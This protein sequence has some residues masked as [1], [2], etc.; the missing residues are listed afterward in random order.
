[1]GAVHFLEMAR[2]VHT[3]IACRNVLMFQ[4]EDDPAQTIVK[5]TDFGL[6]SCLPDD[7]DHFLSR[8][9]Q[10][11]RWCAPETVASMKWSHATDV[12]SLGTSP[13]EL[14]SDGMVPWTRGGKRADVVKKLQKL[15]QA[16][17]W[18]CMDMDEEFPAPEPG[19]YPLVAHRV[20]Q[21]CLRPD[22]LARPPSFFVA[23]VFRQM[24]DLAEMCDGSLTQIDEGLD[25]LDPVTDTE[26]LEVPAQVSCAHERAPI[27]RYVSANPATS[28]SGQ[29]VPSVPQVELSTCSNASYTTGWRQL[30]ARASERRN[31]SSSQG[32]TSHGYSTPPRS[33]AAS[34]RQQS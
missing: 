34:G 14:F 16:A 5:L 25:M 17:S 3:D 6:A 27:R 32:N 13:W 7:A 1:M 28:N 24:V 31:S 18:D 29:T 26:K 2:V 4:L 23:V 10:A 11:T 20:V 30:S 9:P 21:A 8:Q 22:A 33:T 12:W 15:A 19:M